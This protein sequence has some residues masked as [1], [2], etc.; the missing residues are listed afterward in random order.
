MLRLAI[1][2]VALVS[3][4]VPA[5]RAAEPKAAPVAA[6]KVAPPKVTPPWPGRKGKDFSGGFTRHDF[7]LDSVRCIVVSPKKAAPGKPWIWRARFF[8][9]QPQADAALLAKGFH[10]TYAEVGGLFG[11]PKAV[12]RWDKFYAYLTTQH[13]FSKKPALEGMSRGGLIIYNWAAANPTKVSCIYGD[14]P[15]CDFKS[16][17]GG[18]GRGKGSKGTWAQCLKAYGFPEAQA[19]AYKGNPI[20]NLKPLA[21][22]KIPLLNICGA[23]DRVVPMAENTTI[24]AERYR[25]LGGKITVIAKKGVGHHPH[26]LKD[27]KPIVDFVLKHAGP[28]VV[29]H[30]QEGDS[31]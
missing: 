24:L 9:H 3:L 19:M 14:A 5:V 1:V 15:V 10:V 26:S 17:P 2:L 25:K 8:G 31:R 30:Y 21:T 4:A 16:W 11:S 6:P 7:K 27:P 20:D 12:A 23:A 28:V 29:P 18:K 13:G 22:A